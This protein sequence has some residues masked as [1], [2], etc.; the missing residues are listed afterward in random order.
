[1]EENIKK[2]E[3]TKENIKDTKNKSKKGLRMILVIIFIAIFSLISYISLR[4]SYLE[5]KELGEN[6][7]EVFFTNLKYRYSIIGINFALLYFIIYS[8]NRGIKKGL[9]VFFEKEEK[10]MPKLLNKSLSLVIS[11]LVSVVVG[12]IAMEKLLLYVGNTSFGITDQIFNMDIS[13]YMFQKPL[14]E[15]VIYYIIGIVIGLSIYSSIYHVIVFNMFFD[16]IDGKMLK[17]SL[18]LKKL[19]R[20]IRFVG[21]GIALITLLNTQNIL[22][23]KMFS[24]NN[25]IEI[26]GAGYTEA[27]IKLWGDIIFAIVI[28]IGMWRATIHFTNGNNK[29]IIKDI[30]LIPVYLIGLF[31]VI[32]VFNMLFVNSNKYDKEKQ[33]I[34]YNIKN[35]KDAYN[36]NIEQVNL[37]ASGTITQ[38]E[39]DEN[40]NVINNVAIIS[41]EA[42]LNTLEDN[43]TGTGYYLY[44]NANIAKYK[45][46]GRR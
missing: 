21:I 33:Y 16:G 37:N 19:I 3:T 7:V 32:I 18:F 28:I 25:D 31:L 40:K 26:I 9:K 39:V 46:N 36:I 34:A 23:G 45:I 43:Q 20:N 2:T 27:T 5:Y 38:Q 13:Y 17:Q 10:T 29:K 35:T 30:A 15:M 8:T 42:V 1:M 44:R 22:F 24:I 6:F 41:K 4:G 11:A 12:N 14:I